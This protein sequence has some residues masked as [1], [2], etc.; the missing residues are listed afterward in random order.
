[1]VTHSIHTEPNSI[2]KEI[3]TKILLLSGG[4]LV[5]R[6]ILDSIVNSRK[7]LYLI[8]LN[9]VS[10]EP[11]IYE[12][13]KVY[14]SP[15]L[16]DQQ[17]EFQL[18]FDKVIA[19]ES[20][21]LIIPCRDEDVAF[22]SKIR[23]EN[24]NLASKIVCGI[25]SIA[26]SLL[27]KWLSWEFSERLGLPFAPTILADSTL[28]QVYRFIEENGLPLIAK[29]KKG[30]GSLGVF[31]VTH[32]IQLDNIIG[33]SDYIFQKYLGNQEKVFSYISQIEKQG[34]PLFH[35]FEEIKISIQGSIRP[36]GELA[37]V[38]VTEHAMKQGISS[39]VD[40][41]EDTEIN[42]IALEWVQKIAS[43]GWVGPIN[44]Q[45]QKDQDGNIF[46]YEY[47]GR[48]TGATSARFHLGFDEVGLVLKSWL[49]LEIHS[50]NKIIPHKS[51]IRIPGSKA[52]DI[53][54]E[55]QLKENGY[56]SLN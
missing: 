44:I 42:Q 35:S 31:M 8:A 38:I 19:E 1:M 13:D 4:S 2:N 50:S 45:C 5:G 54:K 21:D 16:I 15:S 9:S 17:P 32:E 39:K 55:N 11:S 30:F 6:N 23:F 48:F 40:L 27:D 34:V 26:N 3:K 53:E 24:K 37:G 36:D 7:S 51:V 47:N 41:C 20:P 29:P 43:N 49:G 56:W 12:Y 22:L 14:L 52:L 33:R 25:P 10:R 18:L 28:P 46:I